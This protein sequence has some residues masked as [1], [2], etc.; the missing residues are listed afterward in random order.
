MKKLLVLILCVFLHLGTAGDV[1]AAKNPNRVTTFNRFTDFFATIG[2]SD[3][4]KEKIRKQRREER[5]QA[6]V[7]KE[8][9]KKQ[10]R[11]KKKMEKQNEKILKEIKT[12]RYPHT[13][14]KVV[15]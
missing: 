2:K 13:G 8:Q 12:R 6:R 7:W 4:K 9:Q 15:R 3:R 11:T 5:R 14:N 1:L 10:K